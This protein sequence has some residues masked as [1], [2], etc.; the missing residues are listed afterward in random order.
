[1]FVTLIMSQKFSSGGESTKGG[2]A[3]WAS[4]TVLILSVLPALNNQDELFDVPCCVV[5]QD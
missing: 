4:F 1:M 5:C 3:A 2:K